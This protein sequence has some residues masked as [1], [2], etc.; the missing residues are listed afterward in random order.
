[1]VVQNCLKI[2]NDLTTIEKHISNV[3]KQAITEDLEVD[4]KSLLESIV[5]DIADK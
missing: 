4:Y 5:I 1:M 3:E 2:L